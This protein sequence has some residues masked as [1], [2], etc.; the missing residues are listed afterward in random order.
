MQKVLNILEQHVQWIVLGVAALYMLYMAWAYV[1]NPPVTVTVAGETVTPG[2]VD[3]KVLEKA[4]QLENRMKGG[5]KVTLPQA[6]DPLVQLRT[7]LEGS[8]KIDGIPAFAWTG[9]TGKLEAP[10]TRVNQD[11]TTRVV[12]N[13]ERVESLPT[14]PI[15]V[16]IQ[17]RRGRSTLLIPDPA[18][19]IDQA[20]PQLGPVT[21]MD[22]DWVTVRFTVP[23]KELGEA[24]EAS[25]V[26]Q[27]FMK[28]LFVRAE[29][30]REELQPDG[31]WANA[32]VI[33]PTKMSKMPPFPAANDLK[34]E[35]DYN[36]YA[37]ANQLDI[38][39]PVFYSVGKGDRWGVPGMEDK[40]RNDPAVSTSFDPNQYVDA[41]SDLSKLTKEQ[42]DQVLD[43]RRKLK[44][45]EERAKREAG[46]QPRQP[47]GGPSDG[48]E[49]GG[50]RGGRGP[51]G[52][53]GPPPSDRPT[54]MRQ[55]GN[56]PIFIPGQ[57]PFPAG[58]GGEGVFQ[59]QQPAVNISAEFPIPN[60]EFDPR[61][62]TLKDF[63]G[64]VHD[65][66]V[67]PG[68][69]YRYR[70]RYKIKNPI[71]QTVNVAKE[72]AMSKQFALTSGESEWTSAVTVPAL[73]NFFL[74]AGF[75]AE[76]SKSVKF[77]VYKFQ[78]GTLHSQTFTVYPGDMVGRPDKSIDF[79]TGW[80][81]VD[82]RKD[83]RGGESYVLLTDSTGRLEQRAYKA[84]RDSAEN[85][86]L[87]QQREEQASAVRGG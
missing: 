28:T 53:G 68:K 51:G 41:K 38:M 62:T 24:F 67:Q 45:E 46:R 59:P 43:L 39:Q 56:S 87:R 49:G 20:N 33:P 40:E 69:T 64:W 47:R 75:D 70:V 9:P 86:K 80:T 76:T 42:K 50:P 12:A 72:A 55:E 81:V 25:K 82:V 26:P 18:G 1:I 27:I 36:E 16:D 17:P 14:P 44:A 78:D 29:L 34:A 83:L 22:K 32:T 74:A 79:V 23:R 73:T 52:A 4:E 37:R 10:G 84:D 13:E 15:A 61:D 8:P 77:E 54:P 19:K 7:A 71:Y 2:E 66:T 85:K 58:S 6:P 31:S 21:S 57:Q 48:G 30:V 5:A 63:T 60:G 35:G 11:G 65:D 3:R